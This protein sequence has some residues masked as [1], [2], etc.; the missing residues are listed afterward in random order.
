MFDSVSVLGAPSG[1]SNPTI[2]L[3]VAAYGAI[4]STLVFAWNLYRDL[5]DR[6]KLRVK[7]E[8]RDVIGPGVG[9]LQKDQIAFMITNVGKRAV[10]VTTI[11]GHYPGGGFLIAVPTHTLPFKLEP[12]QEMIELVAP[13]QV[14]P[15]RVRRIGA[16]DSLGDSY[17]A[18][19][20]QQWALQKALL[21]LSNKP[22]RL[23]FRA[24]VGPFLPRW[25]RL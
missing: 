13:G 5:S 21:K 20:R 23:G 17:W 10:W 3:V 24:R 15:K 2:T 16:W 18:P 14:D 25:T 1:G 11:G 6:G 19:I 12:G 7:V 22:E 4:L 9:V 8:L